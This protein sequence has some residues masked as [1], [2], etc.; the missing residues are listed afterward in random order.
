MVSPPIPQPT[1]QQSW[2][3]TQSKT[4]M[5]HFRSWEQLLKDKLG[6]IFTLVL[7]GRTIRELNHEDATHLAAV[8]YAN[9]SPVPLNRRL[10]R[11]AQ[12]GEWH[13]TLMSGRFAGRPRQPKTGS[14]Y[15]LINRNSRPY[16][17]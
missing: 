3:V 10:C 13:R 12:R 15:N 8:Y 17:Q 5:A 2:A 4:L 14:C 9:L 16:A 1:W 11:P 6:H 7:V